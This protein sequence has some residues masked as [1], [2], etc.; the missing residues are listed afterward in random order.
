MPAEED[1]EAERGDVAVDEHGAVCRQ[2]RDVVQQVPGEQ[3][4]TGVYKLIPSI[5]THKIHCRVN[6]V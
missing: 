1:L 4:L 3:H 6:K 5:Y 2:V